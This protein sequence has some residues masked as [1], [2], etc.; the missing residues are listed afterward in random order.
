MELFLCLKFKNYWIEGELPVLNKIE[1]RPGIPLWK[2]H[3]RIG[4]FPINLKI[5]EFIAIKKAGSKLQPAFNK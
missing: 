5:I 2:L 3:K 1:C 4:F